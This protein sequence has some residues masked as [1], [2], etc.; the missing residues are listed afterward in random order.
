MKRSFFFPGIQMWFRLLPF[1][2]MLLW[3]SSNWGCR[4]ADIGPSRTCS[5]VFADSS[6]RHPL[7]GKL[8]EILG[9]YVRKGLPGIVLRVRTPQG[10]WVGS[11]GYADLSEKV[12]MSPCVV[13]K[14]ASITKMLV[15]TLAMKLREE[16]R[17]NPDDPAARFLDPEIVEHVAGLKTVTIRQLMNHTS[18][19]PSPTAQSSFYLAVLNNPDKRWSSREIIRFVYDLPSDR[20]CGPENASYSDANTLLLGLVLDRIL[21]YPHAQAL[22]EKVLDPLGMKNTYYFPHEDLPPQTARGYFDLY[23]NGTISDVTNV[24]TGSGNGYG[25]TYSTV[26]DI[27]A[28]L[29]AVW[30]EGR[31]LSPRSMAEMQRF[32]R[33]EINPE[34]PLDTLYLGEGLM[35]RFTYLRPGTWGIGHTGRDLGYNATGFWFPREDV[36]VMLM[37]NYGTNGDSSLKPVFLECQD[38]I[39][40]TA[41]GI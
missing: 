19:I 20:C 26:F 15:G 31:F 30:R 13:S 1:A 16:N 33:E 5:L 10:V 40:R 39:L 37:V 38:A 2:G 6:E 36:T 11:S 28:Y 27:S 23:N 32:V 14:V 21:G 24:N 7:H 17:L 12:P 29:D 18:G 3:L 22:R 34:N 25:G 35:R 9:R 4:P 8:Q 41:L